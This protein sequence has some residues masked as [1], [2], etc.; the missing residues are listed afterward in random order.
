MESKLAVKS[1]LLPHRVQTYFLH[2]QSQTAA[3]EGLRAFNCF[4]TE[5]KT[6]RNTKTLLCQSHSKQGTTAKLTFLSE[7]RARCNSV[8]VRSVERVWIGL[9]ETVLYT[10]PLWC[11]KSH[12]NLSQVC[13]HLYV[14]LFAPLQSCGSSHI[15]SLLSWTQD[16]SRRLQTGG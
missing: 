15:S 3:S 7:S 12:Q 4:P 16:F 14:F 1:E 2:L 5:A 8:S 10:K 13:C 6:A 9:P 11:H